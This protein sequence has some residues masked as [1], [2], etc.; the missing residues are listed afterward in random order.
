VAPVRSHQRQSQMTNY[1]ISSS[2]GEVDFMITEEKGNK[3]K[4]GFWMTR[5]TKGGSKRKNAGEKRRK[6]ASR[7]SEER[8]CQSWKF[9]RGPKV[10]PTEGKLRHINVSNR[11]DSTTQ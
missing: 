10:P 7:R 5:E 3:N 8:R 11:K 4:K 6:G 9:A 1:A 2:L